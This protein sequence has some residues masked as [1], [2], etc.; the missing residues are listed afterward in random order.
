MTIF[1][2]ILPNLK[3]QEGFGNMNTYFFS[4]PW[5]VNGSYYPLKGAGG[6]CCE[7]ENIFEVTV[8]Y[9]TVRNSFL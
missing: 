2:L 3:I 4:I 1:R 8:I 9:R 5:N 6:C 7:G